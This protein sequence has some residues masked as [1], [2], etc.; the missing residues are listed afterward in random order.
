MEEQ[1]KKERAPGT[2]LERSGSEVAG[3]S[4]AGGTGGDLEFLGYEEDVGYSAPEEDDNPPVTK[5]KLLSPKGGPKNRV[6]SLVKPENAKRRVYNPRE[7]ILLLDVWTKSGLPA[8]DFAALVGASHHTLYNWK[9]AFDKYGPEGLLNNKSGAPRGSRLDEATKRAILMMKE[10]NPEFGVQRISDM[11]YRGFAI[12]VSG[13]AISKYLKDEGYELSSIP[14]RPHPPKAKRFERS[15]PNQMWQ[16]DIFTFMLK[17][18]NR[19][20]HMVAFMDDFSRFIVS[21]GLN[22][23]ATNTLVTEAFELAVS[24]FGVPE[25]VL[26]D[27]GSQYVTWR[28]TSRF[29]KLLT[30]R[31][32][33]QIVASPRRPQTLGKVERFWGTLWRDCIGSAVFDDIEDARKR[34]GMFIDYYNFQ[35]THQGI[36]GLVPA[37]RFFNAAP[38]VLRALKNRVNTNALEYARNGTPKVPFYVTGNLGGKGFSL[39]AKGEH[40]YM[41]RSDG[42]KQEIDFNPPPGDE[43]YEEL[44]EPVC[45]GIAD[46]SCPIGEMPPGMSPLDEG[47]MEIEKFRHENTS[48]ETEKEIES[49][50]G[51]TEEKAEGPESEGDWSRCEENGSSDNGSACR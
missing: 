11:L 13:Q 3:A 50:E 27:N 41:V 40:V 23:S 37:D 19:R 28:G 5:P 1:Q 4:S 12:S 33:K 25:E 34:I 45:P 6:P 14:T 7:K 2:E 48:N 30:K 47:L 20:V 35:R 51:E 49:D 22:A 42:S 17:R 8:K 16:T 31:G 26:T 38:D 32:V 43:G 39:H 18:Q 46:D 24:S 29:N 10:K 21:F 9:K 36:G 15:S 44:P